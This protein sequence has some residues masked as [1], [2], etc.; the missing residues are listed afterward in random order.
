MAL[1]Y[2][3]PQLTDGAIC[4]RP[5][6]LDDAECV[7]Q[8]GEDPAIVKRTTVPAVYS[9]EAARSF[10]ARQRGRIENG[11][12]MSLAIADAVNDQALG[13]LWLGIRP[14]PG[15]LGLGYW[16]IPAA[17]RRGLAA[18]AVRLA[19]DWALERDDVARV[20][21]WLEPDNITSQR[22]LASAGFARE[23]L[24]RSFLVY[25]LRRADAVVFARIAES[26]SLEA[27]HQSSES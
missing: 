7:R 19:S 24:L 15:V 5:W 9:A 17:R 1:A 16:V 23:G 27:R 13:L 3:D 4:L 25:E 8:A 18:R 6:R 20:E 10:I 12:G 26:G 21:A 2:P 11:E 22:L 14:Q